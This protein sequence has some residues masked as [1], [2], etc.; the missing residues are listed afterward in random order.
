MENKMIAKNFKKRLFN[1]ISCDPYEDDDDETH[2]NNIKRICLEADSI[3]GLRGLVNLGSTCFMNCI[4]QALMH[5]PLLRD[6]F[7][8]ESHKCLDNGESCLVCELAR[9]FQVNN[10]KILFGLYF[11]YILN[12]GIL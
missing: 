5:T 11:I 3:I 6:Y 2:K 7:L 10:L 9:L 8:S 12:A 4:V 1:C